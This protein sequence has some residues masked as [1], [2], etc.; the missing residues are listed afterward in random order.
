MGEEK[1]TLMAVADALARVL[2]GVTELAAERVGLN[3]AAGRVLAEDVVARLDHPP[4]DVSSM[5]GYA[6]RSED[7]ATVPV[8]LKLI[9][10][11]SAG[12]GFAGTVGPGETARIF[13]G[14]PLPKGADTV[15][16]QEDTERPETGNGDSVTMLESSHAGRYV[17]PA[18]LDFK[19][20]QVLLKAGTV[21]RARHIG[22]AA[23]MNVPELTVRRKPRVALLSNGNELVEPGEPVGPNQIINSNTF[24]LAAFVRDCGG[25]P[26]N[27]GIARDTV[28]SLREKIAEAQTTDLLVT[29]GGASV[30][31]YDLVQQ[32]LGT[33]GFDLGFY[34]IAMRPGKPLIF[35]HMG[36]LPVLGLPGN[37]VSVGVTA[38]I[39]LK[40]AIEVMLGIARDTAP[41]ETA[42]LGCDLGENDRRQ[43]YLRARLGFDETGRRVVTP[44][45]KQDSSMMATLAA[46]DCL[47][48]RAPHAPATKKGEPV[49][50]VFLP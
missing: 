13:T 46:A 32:V 34:R 38:L 3:E 9:G 50:I 12:S 4:A 36:T 19:K 48:V 1:Q 24:A 17:R 2:E 45:G 49:E 23:G 20:G 29:M 18:G 30:G 37:P 14:A 11:S 21:L 22:L 7:V 27:L 39:F 5:D 31:D 40:P 44:F 10:E 47:I 33:E 35:G 28:E 16:I 26:V 8:T 43:D 41:P 6:V 25:E 15:V 42:L